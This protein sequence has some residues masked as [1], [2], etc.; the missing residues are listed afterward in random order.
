[1]RILHVVTAFPR[2]PNDV[3]SPW[4]VELLKRLKARG[5]DV[6]VFTS[7]YKGG[8]GTEFA[9]IPVHRFRYF[10]AAGENLTHEEGA[11]D[12]MGRSWRHKVLPAFYLSAGLP[13]IWRLCRRRSYDV[14]HVHWPLPHMLFGW[15][16]K[17]ASGKRTRIVTTWY[18]IE[19]RW[20]KSSLK[21]LKGFVRRALRTSDEVVA[22]SS[23]TARE[24]TSIE[25]VPVRV[26]PYGIGF[27]EVSTAATR[28]A[29]GT[30]TILFVGGLLE[31][32][33]VKFLVEA[34]RLLPAR[35]RW[36]LVLVGEGPDLPDLEAQARAG[37]IADRIEFRGQVPDAELHAAYAAADVFVLPAVVDERG[38][39]EGLG[40]VLLEAMNYRLP[41]I[42]SSVG[43][44][45]DI[46]LHEQTGLAIPEKDPQALADAL[47]RIADD[48]ALA[49]RLAT[50]GYQHAQ[51]HFS[52]PAITD[53]WEECYAAAVEK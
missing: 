35:L 15:A 39:T 4:L 17:R 52:W 10:P 14:I 13:A 8:G 31:R 44:I 38:D 5:H 42:G 50:A 16:A 18:G 26:I 34:V 43:G 48:P 47:L 41:V 11:A 40:V 51:E 53:R 21:F 1:M 30:F 33:G 22:I 46:V 49:A 24:I 28:T 19:L 12:R 7:A 3:I 37:G 25:P 2:F 29:D 9:G 6:E 20:V 27:P 32:K 23:A 45:T 36:K